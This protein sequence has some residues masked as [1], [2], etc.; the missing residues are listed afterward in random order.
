MFDVLIVLLESNDIGNGL[1]MTVTVT[2]D[3][4]LNFSECGAGAKLETEVSLA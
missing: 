3:E 2:D 1:F 4:S